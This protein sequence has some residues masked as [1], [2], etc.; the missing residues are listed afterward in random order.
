MAVFNLAKVMN[1]S[2]TDSRY[3]DA[4]RFYGIITVRWDSIGSSYS[5]TFEYDSIVTYKEAVS[6]AFA[7]A[8]KE[9][10]DSEF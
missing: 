9:I 1:V 4:V 5:N 7:F 8:S 3:D 6:D 10:K 2:I